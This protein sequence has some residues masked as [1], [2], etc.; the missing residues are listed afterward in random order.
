[1]ID[2]HTNPSSIIMS[3]TPPP[4]PLLPHKP[5]PALLESFRYINSMPGKNV[6]G[7]MIDCFQIWMNV[8]S[9]DVLENIKVSLSYWICCARVSSS[10]FCWGKFVMKVLCFLIRLLI[11]LYWLVF[12]FWKTTQKTC[13]V[14]KFIQT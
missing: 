9:S 8:N 1:M 7:K 6:R 4:P 13:T 12:F 10:L 11:A 14:V 2:N 5:D 3:S